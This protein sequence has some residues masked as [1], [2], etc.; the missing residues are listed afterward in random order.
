MVKKILAACLLALLVDASVRAGTTGKISGRVVDKANK[1]GL[2][3]ASVQ[4][5]GTTLGAATDRNGEY[6]I[7]NVPPGTYTVK[8]S[9]IGYGAVTI[10]N[11]KVSINQT[12]T[13]NLEL[14]ES[15][16][17]SEEVVVV[18][19]RPLVRQDATGTV[20]V[21][22]REE[23][24]ALPVRDFIEVVQLRAGVVGED[25]NINIRGGRSNEVA[26]L[27]D[28][29]YVEDPLF[30]GLG[31]RVHNDAIE[32]L[33]FLSGTFSAEYGDA[34]SGV[35]NIVTREGAEK[36]A[37]KL[38][39]RTGEFASPYSG[40]DESRF[41][42]SVSGPTGALPNLSFFLSG[43]SDRRGSWLP[44]GYNRDFSAL[45]K[46]TQRFS[47]ALKATLNYRY[48]KGER[49]SYNHA[50]KYIPEQ[51]LQS[52]T[53]S[54]HAMLDLKHVLSSKSFYDIKFSYFDQRYRLGVLDENGNFIPP[55][56]YLSTA[57]R[58]YK[59]D[60]GNGFEFY[61]QANP[62]DYIDSH[63]KTF[64]AKGDLIWQADAHHELKTGLELKQHDLKLYS[65]YDPQRDNPYF[66]DYDREPVEAAAYVQDKMEFASLILNA[67]LRVDY[68][69]QS[70]PFR[71]NPLD[72]NATVTSTKKWQFS[73]RLGIAHPITARTNFHFSYG[74]FFQNPEYQFLYENS[75]YD[76]SVREPLFG[77]PDLDAQK[78]V[79]YEA[80]LAHQFA[81]TLAASFTAYYKDVTGLIGT[82]YYFPYYDGRYVG[83]T[84]YI[85]EDY[86]N[87]KGFEIDLTLRRT[88]YFSGGLTYTY[89]TA[90]GS[91]SSETEQYP[92]TQES[93]LL[94]YLDFDK[95]HVINAN[96][97]LNFRKAEGPRLFGAPVFEN[98]YWNFVMRTSSGYP[99]TPGGRDVGFVIR[100][101]ERMPWTFS[102]DAEIGKDWRIGAFEIT[103]FLEAINL[104]NYENVLYVY[105]DT[106]LPDQTLTGNN[107]EEYIQDPS[108]YGP[109]RRV[110]VGLRV[111][112]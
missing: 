94:Y 92:G 10:S 110:R 14:A 17:Q 95:R 38:D 6:V 41:I 40:Y 50:W 72:P 31:T 60:A 78:T 62:L 104:T 47:P 87:I 112:M 48:T 16:L 5:E 103:A 82:H 55:E 46:L 91:A 26:Y 93:T 59:S 34:L 57:D 27:V 100:N 2:P 18:A 109:P 96:A 66:N 29:V 9:F 45:G 76:L 58:V 61:A 53:R 77:Q 3:G 49:E 107:S 67:G 21:V 81:P 30:G 71:A 4:I 42:A 88:R 22:G 111:R 33:E 68:A 39:A 37:A 80:G 65:V 7:L 43:E 70:A 105:S 23:I 54:D 28:G 99:Y 44:F 106:G 84:L 19:E 20:A 36:L 64:N 69:D 1:A 83:Y 73:P 56:E 13:L 97:S 90:K 35:V 11:V 102:L 24:Q 85:N 25:G 8:L 98:T 52:R 51:Y 63:T 12:T 86:A 108:N 101:S 15:T 74:H 79:A 32:Q 75:Q 89:S